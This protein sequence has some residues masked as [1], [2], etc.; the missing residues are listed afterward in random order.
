MRY[1]LYPRYFPALLVLLTSAATAQTLPIQAVAEIA[2]ATAP[3]RGID[4]PFGPSAPS[5]L[6]ATTPQTTTSGDALEDE[7]QRRLE[8]ALDADG[9][10]AHGAA[11]TKQQALSGGLGYIVQNFE[12]IDRLHSGRITLDDVKAYTRQQPP[13]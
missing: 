6:A 5:A 10:L 8:A 2:P 9:S 12:R 13:R 7:A 4:G 1:R 11:I 3:H